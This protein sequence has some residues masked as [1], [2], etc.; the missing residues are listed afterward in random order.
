MRDDDT[1]ELAKLIADL[2]QDE[3]RKDD[4]DPTI[5]GLL[6]PE[7]EPDT[8]GLL[9][10]LG[11]EPEQEREQKNELLEMFLSAKREAPP[12]NA[13]RDMIYQREFERFFTEAEVGNTFG[14]SAMPPTSPVEGFGL[15]DSL[16]DSFG[17]S[18]VAGSRVP[19]RR[20]TLLTGARPSPRSTILG[21]L[22]EGDRKVRRVFFSFHYQRDIRRV[23]V[24][25]N[26][27]V[28]KDDRK[29]AGYFDGSLT[30][31]ARTQGTAAVKRL[32]NGGLEGA[33][34][35]CVLAGT[36]TWSRHWVKYEVFKSIERG[37]GLLAAQIHGL[38]DMNNGPDPEGPNPFYYLA[39]FP[40][41]DDLD[42]MVPHELVGDRWMMYQEAD[43]I[44][45]SAHPLL[46]RGQA[47][48]LSHLFPIY[49]WVT[50]S[51]ADNFAD[52]VSQ[53]AKS[54]GRK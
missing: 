17:L 52:W 48:R 54:A 32:I 15:F 8:L 27:W 31:K 13:L 33:S 21:D 29:A 44:P 34:V 9:G 19:V 49:D 35:T 11:Y 2:Y 40:K 12:R 47:V 26:S 42:M 25:R 46:V 16:D 45:V 39:L 28:T 53:A 14:L 5:F 36:E 51:G 41:Q 38:R 3:Q 7:P 10:L 20:P 6:D 43:P 24:V 4:L 22:F 18:T 23:F 30:E 50:D 1:S 37:M